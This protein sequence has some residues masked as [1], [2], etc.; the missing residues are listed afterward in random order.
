M[1]RYT[2]KPN[3]YRIFWKTD[4]DTDVGIWKTENT[5]KPTEKTQNIRYVGITEGA[6]NC[7]MHPQRL[8]KLVCLANNLPDAWNYGCETLGL[9]IVLQTRTNKRWFTA[10]KRSE[11]R[12]RLSRLG[13]TWCKQVKQGLTWYIMPL[14][15]S[16][17]VLLAST[18]CGSSN[19]LQ[20]RS[21]IVH[22]TNRCS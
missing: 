1:G 15:K 3:R 22:K 6:V 9:C 13:I 12:E 10:S 19:P 16:T 11:T 20:C 17:L 5:E 8:Q 2:E 18:G 21:S 7:T 14:I 4:T